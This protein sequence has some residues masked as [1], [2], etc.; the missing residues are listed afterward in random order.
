MTEVVTEADQDS[1]RHIAQVCGQALAVYNH[2]PQPSGLRRGRV[3]R[4]WR[5]TDRVHLARRVEVY[6]PDEARRF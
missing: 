4:S 5:G 6:D 2:Q 3:Q 1:L